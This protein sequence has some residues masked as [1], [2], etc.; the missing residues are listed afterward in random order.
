MERYVQRSGLV[1]TDKF[2][3]MET[4]PLIKARNR[5]PAKP[6]PYE[7]RAGGRLSCHRKA[8]PDTHR[9]SRDLEMLRQFR[10]IDNPG[11]PRSP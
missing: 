7:K 6:G 2:W 5:R 9:R 3:S 10:V 11:C 1:L 8:E 4:V